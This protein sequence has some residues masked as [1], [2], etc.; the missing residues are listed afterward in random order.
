[1]RLEETKD[2]TA[3]NTPEPPEV[4]TPKSEG[5][6]A[7]KAKLPSIKGRDAIIYLPGLGEGSPLTDFEA[8]ARRIAAACDKQAQTGESS[9]ELKEIRQE[10]HRS[11]RVEVAT[12]TRRD[13]FSEVPVVDLYL[14]DYTAFHEKDRQSRSAANQ[15]FRLS[16][17]GLSLSMR[18]LQA[19]IFT[20]AL[21]TRHKLQITMGALGLGMVVVFLFLILTMAFNHG[22]QI[23]SYLGKVS[24][25]VVDWGMDSALGNQP[26]GMRPILTLPPLP[27][28]THASGRVFRT[29]P[30]DFNVTRRLLEGLIVISAALSLLFKGDIKKAL[31]RNT[32]KLTFAVR[33]LQTGFD[34]G[35]LVGHLSALMEHIVEKGGKGAPYRQV[36]IFAQGFGSLLALDAVFPRSLPEQRYRIVNGLITIGCPY[37]LVRSIWPNYFTGRQAWPDAPASWLNVYHPEDVLA[38]DFSEK[39]GKLASLH[40]IEFVTDRVR[41]PRNLPMGAEEFSTLHRLLL[42]GFR[43]KNR[44]W[45][46]SNDFDRNCWDLVIRELYKDDPIL[47]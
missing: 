10:L 18:V 32:E 7:A 39:S 44:Y 33:Y 28:D 31:T 6:P 24:V 45:N 9:F 30:V 17:L 46:G 12:I 42:V 25:A 38:S 41:V 3:A 35:P 2:W 20:R 8:M 21:R 29:I 14:L 5:S 26:D 34:Q 11:N 13:G 16:W 19:L 43:L 36:H 4:L 47:A 15:A 1:V 22:L 40:G 37:D 23:A 27:A